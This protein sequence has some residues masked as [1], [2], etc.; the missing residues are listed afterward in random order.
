MF[1]CNDRDSFEDTLRKNNVIPSREERASAMQLLAQTQHAKLVLKTDQPAEYKVLS[2]AVLIGQ[3][4][5]LGILV[6]GSVCLLDSIV[7][8][9]IPQDCCSAEE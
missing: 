9:S 3:L 1:C 8:W 6:W 2:L 7:G 5:V 4:L